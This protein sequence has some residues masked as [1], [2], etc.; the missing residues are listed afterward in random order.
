MVDQPLGDQI[1]LVQAG[2]EPARLAAGDL[3]HLLTVWRPE[4]PLDRDY[5]LFVHIADAEGRPLAQW[6]GLP[7]MNT[8]RSSQWPVGEPFRDHTLVRLPDDMPAGSYQVIG[9]LGTVVCWSVVSSM[10]TSRPC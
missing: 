3:L 10:P 1:T 4:Q 7:G 9:Q 2:V 6:D 8:Q 5:K